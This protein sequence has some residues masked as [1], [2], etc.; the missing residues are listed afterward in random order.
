MDPVRLTIL[1]TKPTV[2]LGLTHDIRYV[3][4]TAAAALLTSVERVLTMAARGD[5]DIDGFGDLLELDQVRRG[6]GWMRLSSG[7]VDLATCERLFQEAAG[8]RSARVFPEHGS[9][10]GYSAPP[11]QGIGPE[12]LH[13]KSMAGLGGRH[14][15]MAPDRYVVCAQ[16]PRQPGSHAAWQ[17]QPV[18]AAGPGR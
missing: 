6:E 12:Q 1:R 16:A 18:R 5:V 14:G 3:S 4:N 15:A 17:A 9:L 2:M 11:D 7:W 10:V 13:A 8:D